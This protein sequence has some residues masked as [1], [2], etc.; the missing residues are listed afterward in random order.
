MEPAKC[1]H[2]AAPGRVSRVRRAWLR[3]LACFIAGRRGA[4][5]VEFAFVSPILIACLLGVTEFGYLLWNRHSLEFAVEETGRMVLTMQTITDDAITADLKSRIIN[6]D[7]SAVTASVARETIGAT[8]FVTINVSYTYPFM[9][10]GYLG[11]DPIALTTKTRVPL[12][13]SD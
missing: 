11:V 12:R 13:Q 2:G 5:M 10:G 3:A 4:A 6:I 1:R 8:T 9:F 7:T